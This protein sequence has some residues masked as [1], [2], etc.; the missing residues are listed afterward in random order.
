MASS[1]R[2]LIPSFPSWLK[3]TK[4]STKSKRSYI[5]TLKFQRMSQRLLLPNQNPQAILS[6][7][8]LMRR[9]TTR[10]RVP[11]TRSLPWYPGTVSRQRSFEPLHCRYPYTSGEP[12]GSSSP[13]SQIPR[14]RP[15]QANR[16][17]SNK[18]TQPLAQCTRWRRSEDS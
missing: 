16:G 5:L 18:S 2:S 14:Q 13:C 9:G 7:T 6:R 11:K 4:R 3:L 12:R 10:R 17:R 1:T 8:P 15:V